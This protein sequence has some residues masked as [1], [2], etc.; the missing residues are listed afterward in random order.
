MP[1]EEMDTSGILD[2]FGNIGK[3]FTDGPSR[4]IEADM[5]RLKRAGILADN[6]AKHQRYGFDAHNF[7]NMMELEKEF[8][9]AEAEGRAVSPNFQAG[10]SLTYNEAGN[11]NQ[12]LL[13][14][15][16]LGNTLLAEPDYYGSEEALSTAGFGAGQA[17]SNT[18]S[19]QRRSLDATSRDNAADNATLLRQQ[20]LINEGDIQQQEVTNQGLLTVENADNIAQEQ[21]L[22]LQEAQDLIEQDRLLKNNL[23]VQGLTNEGNIQQQRVTNEGDFAEQQETSRGNLE[24]QESANAAGFREKLVE[25]AGDLATTL[26]D[27]AT[28]KSG[29]S[30]ST[31]GSGGGG[32]VLAPKYQVTPQ[33]MKEFDQAVFD[34]YKRVMPTK[35]VPLAVITETV[36]NA[37][38]RYKYGGDVAEAI[39]DAVASMGFG[40]KGRNELFRD[41]SKDKPFVPPSVVPG[42]PNISPAEA[43][44]FVIEFAKTLGYDIPALMAAA[45]GGAPAPDAPGSGMPQRPP[46]TPD[47]GMDYT[48]PYQRPPPPGIVANTSRD[49]DGTYYAPDPETGEHRVIRE[50]DTIEGAPGEPVITFSRGRWLYP[51]GTPVQ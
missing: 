21:R 27:P 33:M 30:N 31:T 35:E 22:K 48:P 13:P 39:A 9:A 42:R 11:I 45:R 51:D 15:T 32:D 5:M 29:S 34:Y 12:G 28:A 43:N 46:G 2:V 44:A 7:N 25:E 14:P 23:D 40:T 37:A 8:A 1:F 20:G 24:V 26:V 3:L 19:G 47:V 4:A 10:N 49:L 41:P 50:G 6:A 17:W 16:I 36:Q 38:E 18:P